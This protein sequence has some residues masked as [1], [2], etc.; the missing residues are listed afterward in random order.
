MK[1]EREGITLEQIDELIVVWEERLRRVD[2]NLLSLENEGIYQALAGRAGK[3]AELLGA[4]RDRV[5]PVLD[6]VA[7]LFEDRLRLVAIVNRARAVRA[8][9]STLAFWEKDDKITEISKLLRGRSIELGQ[10]V[11]P[12]AERSLLDE[13]ARDVTTSPDELL[14]SMVE[15]FDRARHTLLS[16]SRAYQALDP[17]FDEITRALD[18]AQ[19]LADLLGQGLGPAP[20]SELDALLAEV[21]S[22]RARVDRDPLGAEHGIAAGLLPRIVGLQ[23]KLGAERAARDRALAAL[24]GSKALRAQLDD[25]HR[26]AVARAGEARAAA[27]SSAPAKPPV[28]DDQIAGLDA[29]LTKIEATI[30]SARWS[31]AEVGLSRWRAAAEEYL[32][33]DEQALAHAAAIEGQVDE[34]RG[35]LRARRAQAHALAQKGRALGAGAEALATEAEALLDVR[36]A[37][38]DEARARIERYEDHIRAARGA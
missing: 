16:V 5:Y 25:V 24:Q 30:A 33:A 17:T 22:L 21:S 31:S 19:K 14:T 7:E 1:E 11:R 34:L 3:R 20:R 4:T 9:I 23:A 18:A 27:A 13:G 15:R 28:S 32:A 2:E 29:W 8:T 6:S 35:R 38:I 36:P 10:A 37:R 26:R 12:L